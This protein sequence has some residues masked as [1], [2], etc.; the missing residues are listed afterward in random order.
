MCVGGLICEILYLRYVRSL[1][2]K[3]FLG[4]SV[5]SQTVLGKFQAPFTFSHFTAALW[6]I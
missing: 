4:S 2:T 6:F 5:F 1:G 3:G